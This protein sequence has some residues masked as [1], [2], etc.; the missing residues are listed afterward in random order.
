MFQLTMGARSRK[1]PFFDATVRHGATHFSVYNHTY[2]ATSFGDPKAEYQRLIQGASLWDVS[3][4]R[5]V[6]LHGPDAAALA[7][8]LCPRDLSRCAIDQGLYVPLCDHAGHIIN[9]PILLKLDEDRFWLSIADSDIL[10]WAR[11]I[12]AEKGFDAQVLEPDV[13]P[14]AV[15]GPKAEAVVANL[16]GNWVKTLR[17][18]W[19]KETSLNGIPL[20]VA[21]S[22]WSK[23][24]G[25]ELYLMDGSRG[26]ELWNEVWAAGKAYAIGPGTPNTIERTESGLLSYGTETDAQTNPLELGL[27]QYMDLYMEADFIGKDA[28]QKIAA[29]GPDRR[30]TG[31]LLEGNEPI[32]TIEHQCPVTCDG[33]SVGFIS[34]TAYSPRLGRN[35]GIA[36][37]RRDIVEN[38]HLVVAELPERA[39]WGEITSLPFC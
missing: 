23:Q 19:F 14:L 28:L 15:Q 30:L 13:S 21:R 37:L 20:V 33:S 38:R 3:C 34:V 32:A 4:Q 6:E 1:S 31:L 26:L 12:C 17:Y 39:H 29:N 7:Q 25:F 18:F 16:L 8:Y 10:L 2:M 9:D 11:A 35:I 24:G 5:Q 27:G 36:L 22:G